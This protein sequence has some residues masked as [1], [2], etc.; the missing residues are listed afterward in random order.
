MTDGILLAELQRDRMLL[1]LRHDHHRR[2]PRAQPQHRLHPRLPRA[3]CCPSRPD[4]KV[5]VT[6]ATID[7]ERFSAHFGGAPIDRGVRPHL[8]GRGALPAARADGPRAATDRDQI[9]RRSPTRS[10]ELRRGGPGRRARVPLRRARDPRHRRRAARASTCPTPRSCRCTP[11]CRPPS[12]TA[13]SQPHHGPAD[14]A[15]HQRGRDV[16]HRA[17]ASATSSTPAPPASPATATGTKVQRLPIEP[18]SQAS[19][20]QRAGRCG[21]VRRRHLHPALRRGGLRRPA[22]VHRAGDP[23]HQPGLGHPA[24][25]RPRPRRHRRLPV[26]RPARPPRHHRRRRCCSR[27][28]ARSSPASARRPTGAPHRRSAA[29]WPGC[30]STPASAAWSS[31]PSA[32]AAC[33][34][35]WSSPPPCRS[36]TPASARPSEQAR[37]RR[38][39]TPASPTP[40]PTSSPSSTCGATCASSSSELSS[41]QFRRL[42]RR[43]HLNF[44]RIREWQDVH[45]QLRQVAARP[46]HDARTAD[47]GRR[48]PGPPGAAGRAA[49]A[50]SGMQD[51]RAPASTSGARSARFA[52]VPGLGAGQDAGRRG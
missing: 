26:R 4:L 9:A 21:R 13:C 31:R 6:S 17:R 19:A 33:A 52:I 22:R 49:V 10:H 8:P 24:D 25:D 20:N 3:S 41:S 2:G 28:S 51:R 12:S 7:T 50:T 15:G 35:C 48:R 23:A 27:S 40:T 1:G 32:T 18:V 16:A 37:G 30:R 44:L 36:R 11:A 46:R 39:S 43:E 38:S 29:G 34:R 45:S 47:A 5:I 14:R 42:C